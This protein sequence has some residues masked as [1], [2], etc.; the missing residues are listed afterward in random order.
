MR[1]LPQILVL[2]S[3]SA[4]FSIGLAKE[5]IAGFT[6]LY[7]AN[8]SNGT[9]RQFSTSGTDMGNA[10]TGLSGPG[11]LTFVPSGNLFVSDFLG[12]KIQEYSHQ[13]KLLMTI[14]TSFAP[15]DVSVT[16]GGSLLVDNYFS[17]SVLKYSSNGQYLGVFSTPSISRASN[18]AF[19]SHGNLYV[20]EWIGGSVVQ[21]SSTGAVSTNFITDLPG[22]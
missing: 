5:T 13:G 14:P 22:V 8:E 4:V 21:I 6:S 9:V 17:G 3:L 15:A 7:V 10:V 19:D 18:N 11:N 1:K 12:D 16:S 20:S 2:A